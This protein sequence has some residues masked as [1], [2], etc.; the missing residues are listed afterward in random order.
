MHTVVSEH[1]VAARPVHLLCGPV[2]GRWPVPYHD[3]LLKKNVRVDAECEDSCRCHES[4]VKALRV[5]DLEALRDYK[6]PVE[7]GCNL[8]EHGQKLAYVAHV[9]I[10][11]E[12]EKLRQVV[13][14]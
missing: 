11:Y 9:K 10:K 6:V 8:V 4:V 2:Q 5:V 14:G 1:V 13:V 3:V 12:R 7:V